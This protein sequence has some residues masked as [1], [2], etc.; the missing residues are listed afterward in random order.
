MITTEIIELV[1][2]F[3]S[4]ILLLGIAAWKRKSPAKL[5]DIP[6]L[7]QLYRSLGLSIE[8]GTR[9]H[10][11]LG[12]GGLLDARGGSALAGLAALRYIA[13]RTSVSDKPSVASAGDPVIGLLT[14]DTLQAGYEAAGA[15]ELYI[16]TTGRVAGLNPFGFAAGSMNILQNESISTH[17]MIGHFGPEAALLTETADRENIHIIGATDDLAGQAVL[18]ANTQHALIGEELFAAGAYMGAGPTHEASLTVQDILRWLVILA[19]L[20]GAALNF[21]GV[22]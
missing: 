13:E 11:S 3:F 17:V 21:L 4:A 20:G 6:A 10:V 16:P 5:R 22:F 14:Q 15:G 8:E 1:V 12:H 2:I 9:L 18:F 7:T 19:L